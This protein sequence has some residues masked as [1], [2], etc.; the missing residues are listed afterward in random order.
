MQIIQTASRFFKATIDYFN[1]T[2]RSFVFW[3]KGNGA[4]K[5]RNRKDQPAR[6]LPFGALYYFGD[7]LDSLDSFHRT[8]KVLKR[9]DPTGYKAYS[10]M[11]GQVF[12]SESFENQ[13]SLSK[14]WLKNRP[15]FGMLHFNRSQ[16]KKDLIPLALSYYQ[17]ID[18]PCHVEFNPE[19]VYR[20]V[21]FN[22]DEKSKSGIGNI[23]QF[24]VS[25]S[26]DGEIKV[27]REK[28]FS[29]IFVGAK[30]CRNREAGKP[31]KS[32][33]KS[34]HRNEFKIPS[35]FK[36]FFVCESDG[37]VSDGSYLDH[38]KYIFIMAANALSNADSGIRVSALKKGAR[39][40]FNIDMLRTPYFFKDREK[41]INQNGNTKKIFHIV[42]THKRKTNKG[43][44]FVKTH[45]RGLTQFNW[46]SYVIKI[47]HPKDLAHQTEF[48]L[49]GKELSSE[50]KNIGLL[51]E[52]E[53][54][55]YLSKKF[56]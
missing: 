56:N 16:S 39:C 33:R 13:E 24:H 40:I 38:A 28:E 52:V 20:V 2:H 48:S 18:K 41:T 8:I 35:K 37:S 19:P 34:F 7:L 50:S 29:P 55:D 30:R 42:R 10:K 12:N 17:K 3:R 25:V 1:L 46:E 43:E 21:A 53:V 47:K 44:V 5:N 14:Y 31:I 9:Y 22:Y 26:V 23:F 4:G 54:A 51:D 32:E 11:G 36:E 6:N 15:T 27:L 45:F 49:P